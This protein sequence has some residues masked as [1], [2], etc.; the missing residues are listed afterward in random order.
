MSLPTLAKLQ[1]RCSA[2]GSVASEYGIPFS[3][4]SLEMT[5]Q[6]DQVA[7]VAVHDQ[8]TLTHKPP[9]NIPGIKV[10]SR[11]YIRT[12]V[13]GRVVAAMAVWFRNHRWFCCKRIP[14]ID[15]LEG[16]C[17]SAVC[18]GWRRLPLVCRRVDSA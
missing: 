4:T 12:V 6:D 16:L 8:R 17:A 3:T 13:V 14:L 11:G 18:L 5:G 7:Q 2:L 10:D 15:R 1:Q 9:A